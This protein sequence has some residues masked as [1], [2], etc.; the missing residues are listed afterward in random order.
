MKIIKRKVEGFR[1]AFRG[2][3]FMLKDYNTLIHLP[4]GVAVGVLAWAL[5][6]PKPDFFWLLWS[7]ALM[8]ITET[9]NTA[10]EKVVD[11]ASPEYHPLAKQAKDLSAAA[12][13]L[14]LLFAILMG[15]IILAPKIWEVL[16]ASMAEK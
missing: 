8:W 2:L 9:F 5:E 1:H 3:G 6:V 4:S 15:S 10:L 16:S 11:L 13:L 12:V 7:I 14:S